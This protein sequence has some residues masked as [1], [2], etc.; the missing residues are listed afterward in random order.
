[1]MPT[2]EP[3]V[4]EPVVYKQ[5]PGYDLRMFVTHPAAPRQALRPA[6]IFLHGGSWRKR[7]LHQ[8]NRHMQ[9]LAGLGV[10]GIIADYRSMAFEGATMPQLLSDARSAVRFVRARAAEWGIDPQRI[11]GAGGSAGAHLVA[12]AA[13]ICDQGFDDPG[14]DAAVS[15]RPDALMLFNPVLDI[16]GWN[17]DP[18]RD[19]AY[20]PCHHV[21]DDTP[22]TFLCYGELDRALAGGRAFEQAMHERD[23]ACELH[24][25]AGQGHGFFNAMYEETFTPALQ[26]LSSHGVID[27]AG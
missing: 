24:C 18:T 2:P 22:P 21:R 16:G 10:T 6:A 23:R 26:F 5:T 8:F 15:H 3:P 11:V 7:N 4:G 25:F 27:R 9:R 12:C 14:D 19:R 13:T 20:S 1:M 17:G